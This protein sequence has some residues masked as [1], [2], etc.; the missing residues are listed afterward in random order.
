[1]LVI[2]RKVPQ[3][4]ETLLSWEGACYLLVWRTNRLEAVTMLNYGEARC[5]LEVANLAPTAG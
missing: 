5:R 3:M 4:G 2:Y 1:M